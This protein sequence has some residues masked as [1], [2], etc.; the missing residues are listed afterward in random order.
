KVVPFPG[1]PTQPAPGTPPSPTEAFAMSAEEWLKLDLADPDCL[2][3]HWLTTTTR[4][5]MFAPTGIGKTMLAMG[6]GVPCATGLDFPH[7]KTTRQAKVLLIDGEMSRRLLKERLRDE[8]RRR[9]VVPASL[10]LHVLSHEDIEEFA[11]L[12]SPEGQA[13]I[14][15][16][17]QQLGGID[18]I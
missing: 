12:N 10:T 9:R 13:Q 17:I 1:N 11:P 8:C 2:L 3:G 7:W 14:E 5:F 6:I 4:A 18:L 15:H 16:E